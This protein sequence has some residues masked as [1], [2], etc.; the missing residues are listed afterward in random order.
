MV[1]FSD[2]SDPEIVNDVAIGVGV[3]GMSMFGNH[4]MV[5]TTRGMWLFDATVETAPSLLSVADDVG[6]WLRCGAIGDGAAYF[7]DDYGL[8]VLDLMNP[9]LPVVTGFQRIEGGVGRLVV[10]PGF[11]WVGTRY[12]SPGNSGD[13]FVY[14]IRDALHPVLVE[15]PIGPRGMSEVFRMGSHAL[16]ASGYEGLEVFFTRCRYSAETHRPP[17]EID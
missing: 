17:S 4:L 9:E 11:L 15:G 6:T 2:P 14:D 3:R 13:L 16:V 5:A 8:H 7:G 10:T 12:V 1:D